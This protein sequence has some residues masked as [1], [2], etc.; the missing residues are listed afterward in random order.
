MDAMIQLQTDLTRKPGDSVVFQFR[1]GGSG[2]YTLT[3]KLVDGLEFTVKG[4]LVPKGKPARDRLTLAME[5]DS[6][7]RRVA[8]RFAPAGP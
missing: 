6:T 8:G 1:N 7:T 4:G 3:G 2:E 5:G